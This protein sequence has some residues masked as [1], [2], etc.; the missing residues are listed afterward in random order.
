MARSGLAGRLRGHARFLRSKN[1]F[2]K[3][4]ACPRRRL[5][6]PD[7]AIGT[8]TFAILIALDVKELN[9]MVLHHTEHTSKKSV[10]KRNTVK[11]YNST[12]PMSMR[13]NP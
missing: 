3:N 4:R 2:R 5:A 11:I 1:E 6:R 9:R 13:I 7:L 10:L 8:S 12:V